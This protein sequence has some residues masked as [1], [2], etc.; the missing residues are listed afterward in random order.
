MFSYF[1]L[2]FWF[3]GNFPVRKGCCRII[4]VTLI[5]GNPSFVTYSS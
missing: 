4:L 1:V 5:L 3:N 2:V